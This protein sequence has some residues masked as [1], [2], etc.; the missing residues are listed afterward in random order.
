MEKRRDADYGADL[1]G[2]DS[3]SRDIFHWIIFGVVISLSQLWLIPLGYYLLV[4]PLTLVGLVG[5]GSLLFFATTIT[6]K[7]AGEYFKRVRGHHGW[8]TLLCVTC[9]ILV[10]MS[11]VFAYAVVVAARLGGSEATALSDERV[12]R[13]SLYLAASGIIFSFA[14]TLVIRAY[15]E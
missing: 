14:Y 11:S 12:T 4:K 5:N 10:V 2:Q 8:A 9:M 7:T 15:G 1:A 3:V 6:S 13:V